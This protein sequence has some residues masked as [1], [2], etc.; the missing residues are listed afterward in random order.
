MKRGSEDGRR[1]RDAISLYTTGMSNEKLEAE[2]LKLDPGA[3]ARLASKLLESL[4]DL[5][6]EEIDRLWAEEANRRDDR[7]DAQPGSG[8][9][10]ADVLR[11]VRSRLR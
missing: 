3:R 8:K 10:A 5:S 9:S 6:A 4:D 1:D 7:M 11:D 2:A